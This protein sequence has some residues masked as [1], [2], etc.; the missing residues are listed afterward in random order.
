M[1]SYA[2]ED[3]KGLYT[4]TFWVIFNAGGMAGGLLSF[5]LN[6]SE[7]ESSGGVNAASYFAFIIIMLVGAVVAVVFL[8]PP[9]KVVRDDG[10]PIVFEKSPG[11]MYEF[12]SVLNLFTNINMLLMIPLMVQ[13]NWFY[14]YEFNGVNGL[15]FN[16][17][18]RGFNSAMYWGAQMIGAVC[19][20][21][22][23]DNKSMTRQRRAVVGL[24]VTCVLN[25]L[26]WIWAIAMQFNFEGG[27]YDRD[28]K[29]E[30]LI[31]IGDFSRF[32]LPFGLFMSMGLCD[33]MVQTYAYWLMGSLANGPDEC[34]RFAGF[35][36]GIQSAGACVAWLMD[37]YGLT[38]KVQLITCVVL[39]LVFV[40][41]TYLVASWVKE[42]SMEAD[43]ESVEYAEEQVEAKEAEL[44][45]PAYQPEAQAQPVYYQ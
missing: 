41:P 32:I 39:S 1:M 14:G 34:A 15:L 44:Y 29:P 7:S 17:R 16:A 12:K 42:S 3:R 43:E 9:N 28:T 26:Q 27:N 18:T 37:A 38:Y 6:F 22:F 5:A 23:L 20:G 21:T 24:I 31:D 40:P 19:I 13:S 45:I 4:W 35:Y 11:P 25:T 36:K 33:S 8:S 2:T 30:I 10:K